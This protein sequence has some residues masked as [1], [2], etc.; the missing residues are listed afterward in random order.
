MNLTTLLGFAFAATTLNHAAFGAEPASIT[1][2]PAEVRQLALAA[3]ET[4]DSQG[5]PFAI[6]DKKNASVFV[7]AA[8]GSLRGVSPVLLGL[9]RGDESVAGIGERELSEIRPEERTTPAGR[10]VAEPGKNL[11]GEDIVWVDYDAAVSM[12]RV[13]ASNKAERRLERL[14]SDTVDDNRISYGCINVPASF[15]DT[16]IKSA[17]GD[18]RGVIYILPETHS[19]RESFNFMRPPSTR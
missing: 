10:F 14:A 13:R 8:D 6:V 7:Y 17:L 15:Y 9:A 18:T 5:L 4:R 2:M 11:Q 16:Y 19:V 3:V 1:D 12:H